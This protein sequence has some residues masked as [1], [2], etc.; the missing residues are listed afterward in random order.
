MTRV[1]HLTKDDEVELPVSEQNQLQQLYNR[2]KQNETVW[3]GEL[4]DK[5]A[6]DSLIDKNL[7]QR[8]MKFNTV[9]SRGKK[10]AGRLK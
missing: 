6:C 3:N 2:Y 4:I 9:T 5:K 10:V 7:A 1:V 8:Q